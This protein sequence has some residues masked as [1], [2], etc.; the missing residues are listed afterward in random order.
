MT[1]ITI[2]FLK[3]QT[4]NRTLYEAKVAV[5][6]MPVYVHLFFQSLLWILQVKFCFSSSSFFCFVLFFVF[7]FLTCLCRSAI[8]LACALVHVDFAC[9]ISTPHWHS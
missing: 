7:V 1:R 2:S 5:T 8:G 3:F 6:H 9:Y 4:T